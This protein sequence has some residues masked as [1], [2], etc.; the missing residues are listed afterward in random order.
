LQAAD[1][2]FPYEDDTFDVVVLISVFTHMVPVEVD[3]Y[4]SEIARVLKPGGHIFATYFLLTPES[5]Q[6]METPASAMRFKHNRGSYRVVSNRVPELAVA[7]D[8]PYVRELYAKHGL[9]GEPNVYVGAWCG[10]TGYWPPDSG[11]GDQDTAVAAK[12]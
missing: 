2:H 11:L 1:Y 6:L 8:E 10:R 5:L 9:S 3:H 7:Y 12:L 4:I